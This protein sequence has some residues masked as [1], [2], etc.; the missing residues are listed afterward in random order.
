M[1]V[2]NLSLMLK[3]NFPSFKKPDFFENNSLQMPEKQHAGIP[4]TTF[5]F[6]F[7]QYLAIAPKRTHHHNHF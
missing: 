1:I 5:Y 6:R 4:W 7:L 3:T 2:E